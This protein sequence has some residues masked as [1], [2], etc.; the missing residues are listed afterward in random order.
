MGVPCLVLLFTDW[1][2]FGVI[3][4]TDRIGVGVDISFQLS[5][6]NTW[7]IQHVFPSLCFSLGNFY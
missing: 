1:K 3:M 5:R 7:E 2:L 6:V 4:N